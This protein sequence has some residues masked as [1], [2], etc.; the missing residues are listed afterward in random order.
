MDDAL[1]RLGAVLDWAALWGMELDTRFR[2]LAATFEP[3]LERYPWGESD[4]RRVQVLFFP[5]STILASL[6]RLDEDEPALVTFDV[7]HLVDVVAAFDGATVPP[8][9]LGRPEPKPGEWGPRFSLEG[10]STTADGTR[11]TLTVQLRTE[12]LE[13]DLFARFDDAEVKDPAGEELPL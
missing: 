2:V 12:D 8:P 13:L 4:D 6:R 11:N 7:A 10:R 5:V 9:L 3:S 1:E